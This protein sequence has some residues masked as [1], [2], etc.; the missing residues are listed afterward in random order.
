MLGK[1]LVKRR[2]ESEDT[3]R[4]V[5]EQ[6]T[7]QYANETW[8]AIKT[9]LKL[10]I[11]SDIRAELLWIQSQFRRQVIGAPGTQRGLIGTIMSRATGGD[12][13][14]QSLGSLPRWAPRGAR[15]LEEKRAFTGNTNWF[16]N[17][18]W[19]GGQ[20]GTLAR[21]FSGDVTTP[22][23]DVNLSSGGILEQIF[24]GISV[25][26]VRNNREWGV[27]SG[28]IKITG[29]HTQTQL[30]T[31]Y[32]RALKFLTPAMLR[33]GSTPNRAL[34]DQVAKTNRDV[35]LH[36]R[37]GRGVYRPTLEPYLQFFLERSIPQAV[38]AR[39]AKSNLTSGLFPRR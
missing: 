25:D 34:L 11:A 16:D 17:T 1:G 26:V 8:G 4:A 3:A 12:R 32:V 29:D 13:P 14:Q 23:G 33:V 36:L 37:G 39:L 19:E 38:S 31:I 5:L 27:A 28:T 9:E 20:G 22:N 15:Y 10:R 7:I 30:A 21:F 18:G 24:G 6:V 2:K 35:A